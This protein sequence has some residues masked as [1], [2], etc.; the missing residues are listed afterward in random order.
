M[1]SFFSFDD[2]EKRL[3]NDGPAS[4]TYA[5]SRRAGDDAK[6]R[7]VLYERSFATFQ[8]L[9]AARYCIKNNKDG[10]KILFSSRAECLVDDLLM[11]TPRG[12]WLY[13]VKYRKRLTW[14]DVSRPFNIQLRWN[15]H[16]PAGTRI[17]L[18]LVIP[19]SE[20]KTALVRKIPPGLGAV[21]VMLFE[22]SDPKHDALAR[23]FFVENFDASTLENLVDY[24]EDAWIRLNFEASVRTI[25]KAASEKARH[26]IRSLEPTYVL[27]KETKDI[28]KG[29]KD[30]R[31]RIMG[32]GLH[33]SHRTEDVG[34][35]LPYA[36]G[37]ESWKKLVA[38]LKDAKTRPKTFLGFASCVGSINVRPVFAR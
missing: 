13:E 25:M 31:I 5:E 27:D 16:F 35:W 8:I 21:N 32:D 7:G 15:K 34:F 22:C 18:A 17:N 3:G 10:D 11:E 4:R 38:L 9:S 12:I 6:N 2:L 36:C 29:I 26:K 33:Y 19:T 24:V 30:L 37:S 20:Q 23:F 14:R 28:L 1:T